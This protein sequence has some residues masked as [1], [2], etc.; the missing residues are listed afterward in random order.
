MGDHVGQSSQL[1]DGLVPVDR[2]GVA[3]HAGVVDEVT[4][5]QVCVVHGQ[6]VAD[7]EVVEV[8]AGRGSGGSEI[9]DRALPSVRTVFTYSAAAS[10]TDM[11]STSCIITLA[12]ASVIQDRPHR[13]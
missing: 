3:S 4:A 7:G 2:V 5:R 12:T 8:A 13:P 1:G 10:C 9:G 11:T 6:L